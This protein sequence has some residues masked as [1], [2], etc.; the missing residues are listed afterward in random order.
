MRHGTHDD[1]VKPKG[2][3]RKKK[4]KADGGVVRGDKIITTEKPIWLNPR[5]RKETRQEIRDHLV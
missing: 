1:P 4:M 3:P 5:Y 2:A